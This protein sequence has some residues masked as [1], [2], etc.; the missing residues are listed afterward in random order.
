MDIRL[1]AIAIAEKIGLLAFAALIAVLVPTLR[2]RILGVGRPQ[3]RGVAALYGLVISMWGARMDVQ[4]LDYHVDLRA[5]GVLIAA[6]LGGSR[7]GALTGALAGLHYLLRVNPDAGF[8]V[9]ASAFVTGAAGGLLSERSPAA[10]RRFYGFVPT[11]TIQL[12]A[13][14]A[15]AAVL[16]YEGRLAT[17]ADAW[18]AVAL[19]ILFNAAGIVVFVGVT[20]IIFSHEEHAVA[21]VEARAAADAANLEAL[22]RRLEPHFLFNALNT[23]RATIR[24]D[25]HRARELVADLADLY[26]YLL[27]HPDDAPLSRE[28][29]HAVA[30]LDIE[31][32]RLGPDRLAVDV[33]LPEELAAVEVPALLLQPLVE[34]AVQHGVAARRGP[35]LVRIEARRDGGTLVV[36]VRDSGEGERRATSDSGSGVALDNLRERLWK[37]FGGAASL[38]LDVQAEVAIAT[39][40]L[41][42]RDGSEGGEKAR[43][44]ATV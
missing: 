27:H 7:W 5:I 9:V 38:V 35:G 15:H 16:A 11:V 26:R 32:A 21:L 3:D 2:N 14:C 13:T 1:V 20:R 22:R 24:R 25:P 29:E 34:N 37:G 39:L 41:P 23:L 18:P 31:R 4:W 42:I 19:Q 44:H 12:A 6:I 10:F 28:V 17:L 43:T 33:D 36:E 30:Y 40:R 8:G